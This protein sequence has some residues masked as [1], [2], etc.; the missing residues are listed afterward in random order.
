MKI[1]TAS[2]KPISEVESYPISV[3][4]NERYGAVDRDSDDRML[5]PA[6]VYCPNKL[7]PSARRMSQR[8]L[9]HGSE[10]RTAKSRVLAA[11]LQRRPHSSVN[12]LPPAEFACTRA[13]VHA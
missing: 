11:G 12:Y 3:R 2:E 8:Q 4:G 9:V 10:R 7:L 5:T 13:E 1:S 6:S